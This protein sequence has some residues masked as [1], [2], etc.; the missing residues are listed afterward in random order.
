MAV[1]YGPRPAE[2][3]GCWRSWSERDK[4][5]AL[6]SGM[7]TGDVKVRRR[8]TG[9]YRTADVAV[10]LD[11]ELYDHFLDWWLIYSQAGVQPTN[12]IEPNGTESLWRFMEPP[13][14]TWPDADPT[15]F[16]VTAKIE[17]LPSWQ[18]L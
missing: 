4:P 3:S 11:A 6:R 5:Q 8:F 14:I 7:D 2:L 17:R 16:A 15:R 13:E 18:E 1:T 10:I 9:R 12:M